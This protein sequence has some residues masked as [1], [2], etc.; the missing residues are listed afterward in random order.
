LEKIRKKCHFIK[1][2]NKLPDGNPH[3]GEGQ[4]YRIK[5]KQSTVYGLQMAKRQDQRLRMPAC[6]SI[7]AGRKDYHEMI[8][9]RKIPDDANSIQSSRRERL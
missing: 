1:G 8:A 4:E 3:S 2:K 7:G 6:R 9:M 5:K